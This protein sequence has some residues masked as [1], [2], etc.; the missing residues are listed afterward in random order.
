M[1]MGYLVNDGAARRGGRSYKKWTLSIHFASRHR[2]RHFRRYFYFYLGSNCVNERWS[3]RP[4]P[5][6]AARLVTLIAKVYGIVLERAIN[7]KVRIYP[8]RRFVGLGETMDAHCRTWR[9]KALT[10]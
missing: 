4:G 1:G 3:A 7:D 6:P 8:I 9:A 2:D 5:G 10:Y